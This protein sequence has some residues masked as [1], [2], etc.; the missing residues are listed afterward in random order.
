ML[1]LLSK[2][3][4]LV[5]RE[6]F[7]QV[8]KITCKMVMG[9]FDQ[10]TIEG[11][12]GYFKQHFQLPENM[13]EHLAKY[14]EDFMFSM[15]LERRYYRSNNAVVYSYKGLPY[16]ECLALAEQVEFMPNLLV[17]RKELDKQLM[18]M[19]EPMKQDTLYVTTLMG[20]HKWMVRA[21]IRLH[22]ERSDA[23][24]DA[25]VDGGKDIEK[26]SNMMSFET[27]RSISFL[28]IDIMCIIEKQEIEKKK[29]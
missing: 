12:I 23:A 13:Q 3:N 7:E 16:S 29:A 10:K 17:W 6:A 4:A 15:M 5:L 26:I 20:I 22:I 28:F 25:Y 1:S 2:E 14:M 27:L 8:S 11:Y 21:W 19:H 24:W 9:N 18:S